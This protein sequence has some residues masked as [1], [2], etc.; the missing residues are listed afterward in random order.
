MPSSSICDTY[1][2]D[3]DLRNHTHSHITHVYGEKW[4]NNYEKCN[5]E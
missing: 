5:K 3:I 1:G 2:N 4:N